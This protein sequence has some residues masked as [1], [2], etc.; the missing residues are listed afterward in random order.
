MHILNPQNLKII[1]IWECRVESYIESIKLILHE[2][3]KSDRFD[4]NLFS[5]HAGRVDFKCLGF[6]CFGLGWPDFSNESH[7]SGEKKNYI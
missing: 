3:D 2:P 5:L 6:Y 4:A 1:K 7:F